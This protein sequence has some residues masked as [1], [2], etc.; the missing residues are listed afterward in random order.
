MADVMRPPILERVGASPINYW[1]TLATDIAVGVG[2]AWLGA[3]RYPGSNAGAAVYVLAGMVLWPLFE[4]SLHRWV[5]H[6]RV[7]P[8]FRSDHARHHARPR[9]TAS[10]PWLVSTIIG[11]LFWGA[12]AAVLSGP[13]A[14]LLMSGFYA[15][16]IY[17]VAVHRMQHFHPEVLARWWFFGSQTRLHELHHEE[18]HAH[19]GITTSMWDRVFGTFKGSSEFFQHDE[20][21]VEQPRP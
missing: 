3:E 6:G 18:P 9:E 5:L 17:F 1:A 4:Y 15:G 2:F 19:F 13:A 12:L 11:I 8:A 7:A 14:A 10:T 16:Y 21:V 20:V